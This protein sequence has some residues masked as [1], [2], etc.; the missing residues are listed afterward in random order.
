[1]NINSND[2]RERI[3]LMLT[4]KELSELSEDSTG[5]YVICPIDILLG[6][7]KG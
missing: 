6:H 1:M 4:T 7:Q 5:I 2:P 3:R